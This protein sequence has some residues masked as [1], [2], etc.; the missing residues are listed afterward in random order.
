MTFAGLVSAAI[1]AAGKQETLATALDLSPS[2]LSKR[3]NGEQGW[4]EKEIARLL[5]IA[6]CEIEDCG[7]SK[8]KIGTLLDTLR[9]VMEEHDN[10]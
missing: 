1:A 7:Q 10:G 4:Q 6:G 9:I 3:I 8:K 5:E 2:A